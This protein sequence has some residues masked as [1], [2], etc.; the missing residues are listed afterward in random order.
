MT[1][2][3][4]HAEGKHAHAGVT[5]ADSY[6]AFHRLSEFPHETAVINAR[7]RKYKRLCVKFNYTGTNSASKTSK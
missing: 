4:Y 5:G 3:F 6:L 2:L 7:I 1:V